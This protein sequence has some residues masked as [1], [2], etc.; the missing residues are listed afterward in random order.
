MVDTDG[1]RTRKD[2]GASGV[3]FRQCFWPM[4]VDAETAFESVASGYEPDELPILYSAKRL[5]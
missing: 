1:S 2:P 5:Q 3:H 4:K